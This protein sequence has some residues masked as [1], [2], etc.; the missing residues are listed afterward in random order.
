M[1]VLYVSFNL[2]F[3]MFS[4][5][6]LSVCEI[7]VYE[8]SKEDGLTQERVVDIFFGPYNDTQALYVIQNGDE[9]NSILRI[10][11]E[12]APVAVLQLENDEDP[13]SEKR[14]SVGEKV[15]FD[16][17]KSF[18]LGGDDLI[19]QWDFGDGADSRTNSTNPSHIYDAP[20]EYNVILV[21]T[22]SRGQANLA[23]TTVVVEDSLNPTNAVILSPAEG[24]SFDVGKD[25]RLKAE[26]FDTEGERIPDDQMTWSIRQYHSGGFDF[27]MD[28]RS[29]ND[30]KVNPFPDPEAFA[31]KETLFLRVVLFVMDDN[32][33]IT[34][35]ERDIYPTTGGD[36]VSDTVT[37]NLVTIP[38]GL[39]ISVGDNE[40]TAPTQI[41]SFAN[42]PVQVNPDQYPYRFQQWSDGVTDPSRDSLVSSEEDSATT[43]LTFEAIF[44]LVEDAPCMY[45]ATSCC[46]GYCDESGYCQIEN[47][48]STITD[49]KQ[50]TETSSTA[51][52]EGDFESQDDD[53]GYDITTSLNHGNDEESNGE[54]NTYN[55]GVTASWKYFICLSVLMLLI[56]CLFY[57]G[58]KYL[59]LKRK[60]KKQKK[61]F[62]EEQA[63]RLKSEE[64][65]SSELDN[66]STCGGE[67]ESYDSYSSD[68]YSSDYSSMLSKLP[69]DEE[70]A[71]PRTPETLQ[72]MD[73]PSHLDPFGSPSNILTNH[74]DE[75]LVKLDDL[76][77]KC[78][79]RKPKSDR[80]QARG[81]EFLEEYA[82]ESNCDMTENNDL[83]PIWLAADKE[84][85]PGSP[86]REDTNASCM[87]TMFPVSY[88]SG[89]FQ[90]D[91][92]GLDVQDETL[93]RTNRVATDAGDEQVETK[94]ER[95]WDENTIVKSDGSVGEQSQK[96]ETE[97]D[98]RSVRSDSSSITSGRQSLLNKAD[99]LLNAWDSDNKHSHE[100]V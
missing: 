16:G 88:S 37:V 21:V 36:V 55:Y 87:E 80:K 52:T 51:E 12:G 44:C 79:T 97:D 34:K 94:R 24:D 7:L 43:T 66:N 86:L 100:V 10:R 42:L 99:D 25:L 11:Y 67:S 28:E 45:A 59:R 14:F 3:D 32:G 40:F 20:G 23:S 31:S 81:D 30:F 91:D 60:L 62:S 17:S 4:Q 76:L 82:E 5:F 8:P 84:S 61:R 41:Q 70:K 54:E 57:F 48:H 89:P 2:F 96:V 95:P 26:V 38:Q 29:G 68:Y 56:V 39:N 1:I 77:T 58:M 73:S 15:D 46:D 13:T 85:T 69:F 9:S 18:D 71:L 53:D 19:F 27:L 65:T 78:F 50:S 63:K 93:T 75:T 98:L 72:T 6:S 47:Q 64:A 90:D 92:Q 33:L 74:I 49:T 83:A 35:I 22:N